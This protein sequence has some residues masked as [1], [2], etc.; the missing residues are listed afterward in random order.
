MDDLLCDETK[1]WQE[2]TS[3]T[4]P[5]VPQ[6]EYIPC[7]SHHNS[8]YDSSAIYTYLDVGTNRKSIELE[9]RGTKKQNVVKDSTPVGLINDN[10]NLLADWIT[11]VA[12]EM[13]Q[14][15]DSRHTELFEGIIDLHQTLCK[16]MKEVIFMV[17]TR[18][19][20]S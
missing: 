7:I 20:Q 10:Y 14:M 11:E 17:R 9:K 5:G 13:R 1:P 3:G 19:A 6:E 15:I 12:N 4:H 8:D 2:G 16:A 18:L